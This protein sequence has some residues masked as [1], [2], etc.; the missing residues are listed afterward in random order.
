MKEFVYM[1]VNFGKF[2]RTN[3]TSISDAIDY[4]RNNKLPY[5]QLRLNGL[6]WD[7]F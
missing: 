3:F 7:N 6:E 1:S 4:V 2:K 5:T